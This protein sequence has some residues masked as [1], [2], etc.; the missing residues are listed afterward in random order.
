VSSLT[1]NAGQRV[2][3]LAAGLPSNLFVVNPD[4][5][6]ANLLTNFGGSTHN[7]ATLDVRRRF[8]KGVLFDVNYTF[9]KAMQGLFETLRE[10]PVKAV[11]PYGITHG[12][13]MN[14]IYELPIG[15][16]KPLLG[17]AHGVV[18]QIV[19]G[20]AIDGTGRVQSGDPFSLGNVRLVG[21]TRNQLQDAVGMNFNNGAKIAYFLPQDIIQ[22]TIRAYNTSANGYGS[23]GAPSGRYIAP[24]DYPGCI[25]A[26]PGQCGGT[27]LM[28]YGPHFTRFDISAVKKFRINERANVEFRA[29]FLNAF[30]N[31][32]FIVGS[33]RPTRTRP[34]ISAVSRSARRPTPIRTPP[35]RT[36]PAGG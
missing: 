9:T 17:H 1:G 16:A 36:I 28:L 21:M 24:A 33:A 11:S 4:K 29:E 32:N 13:K 15:A 5:S 20:W 6:R 35:R 18:Q 25:E 7:A 23:L 8:A 26:F 19:G 27:Q 10:G 14:W 2:N 3:A 12:L 34:P 31:I 30:N 22:N